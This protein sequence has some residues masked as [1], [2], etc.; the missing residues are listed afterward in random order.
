MRGVIKMLISNVV[1]VE[2]DDRGLFVVVLV[3]NVEYRFY[4]R[5]DLDI[6]ISVDGVDT[7]V[8]E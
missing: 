1:G 6:T 2:S 7:L 8:I 5:K 3:L 4:I